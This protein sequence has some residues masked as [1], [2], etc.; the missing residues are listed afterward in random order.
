[1]AHLAAVDCP[2]AKPI[3]FT[4]TGLG[5]ASMAASTQA[6]AVQEGT[7]QEGTVPWAVHH[8]QVWATR[9]GVDPVPPPVW[10][11][12]LPWHTVACQAAIPAAVPV[13]WTVRQRQGMRGTP[14]FSLGTWTRTLAR[15]RQR[16][17]RR[18]AS[19]RRT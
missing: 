11:G 5:A 10:V 6:A 3:N 18:S 7:V 8:K 19:S 15:R 16:R 14:G 13:P 9:G 1:M 4:R 2:M 12:R 17:R